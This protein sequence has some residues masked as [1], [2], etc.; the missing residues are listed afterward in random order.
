MDLESQDYWKFLQ[1]LVLS[2][3]LTTVV[4]W[5]GYLKA[6]VLREM[7]QA[8]PHIFISASLHSDECFGMA[9]FDSLCNGNLA[10]L[11]AWGG[12]LDL[13]RNFK[14]QVELVPVRGSNKG[15]FI[16]PVDFSE[17]L[18][19]CFE[20]FCQGRLDGRKRRIPRNYGFKAILGQ[21]DKAIENRT[22]EK[23][24]LL[25]SVWLKELHKQ[26]GKLN[27]SANSPIP[28]VYEGYNDPL[29]Q[30]VFECYGMLRPR[31]IEDP[32]ELRKKHFLIMPWVEFDPKFGK[33]KVE[34]PHRGFAEAVFKC[35]SRV[36]YNVYSVIGM[37]MPVWP[38]SEDVL[39]WLLEH[40][41]AYPL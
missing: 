39:V 14:G 33:I 1:N 9:A 15:P 5:H 31:P 29:A 16:S 19:K 40:G 21:L 28:H 38:V 4:R 3:D 17:Q 20:L 13:Y 18:Q 6:Y 23:K 24:R 8:A 30:G 12:H 22:F 36:C 7:I 27:V 35:D 2:L 34:D 41:Y 11:S 26:V 32:V 37:P 25:P 10:V